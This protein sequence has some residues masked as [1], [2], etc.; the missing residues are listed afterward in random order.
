MAVAGY[1][2][3]IDGGS[4]IDVGNT[5]TYTATGLTPDTAYDFEVRAY[6]E[7]GNRSAWSAVVTASTEPLLFDAM[8][9][10]NVG[11]WDLTQRRAGYT[12]P[13]VK[14]DIG[15]TLTD[16]DFADIEATAANDYKID[17]IYDQ[18]GNGFH[19]TQ[20]T[21]GLRPT[22][23]IS[24]YN[25]KPCFKFT[26]GGAS[27]MRVANFTDWNGLADCQFINAWRQTTL[28]TGFPFIG[29]SGNRQAYWEGNVSNNVYWGEGGGGFNRFT[30]NNTGGMINRFVFDGGGATDALKARFFC[31]RS[32][33]TAGITAAHAATFPNETHLDWNGTP[34]AGGA[35]CSAEYFAFF[36][37]GQD[38]AAGDVTAIEDQLESD[39]FTFADGIITCDG[40]SLIANSANGGSGSANSIPHLVETGL[41]TFT[42]N[43]W[44]SVN[45]GSPAEKLAVEI[46]NGQTSQVS[47]TKDDWR[48]HKVLIWGGTNDLADA[49]GASSAAR[50]DP[51]LTAAADYCQELIDFGWTADDI[52]F[53]TAVT[54]TDAISNADYETDRQ[55]F[56]S[57]LATTLSGI[58]T[59]VD[60]TGIT[61]LADST[62]TDYRVG[63]GVH[64]NDAGNALVANAV[65][66]AIEAT[67]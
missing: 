63:D 47:Q 21:D 22:L 32:E 48:I 1:E 62:D 56:N 5:L 15:G 26:G 65:L 30:K 20:G 12:G 59:V 35:S 44:A 19:F 52:F 50:V 39:Y 55:Y 46:A 43:T 64:L 28:S 29:G 17:T 6:D 25:N 57:N 7:A 13:A 37:I 51:I 41:E 23:S 9:M 42:G 14:V 53:P 24:T 67:L 4:P 49:S 61:E 11:I 54:R 10:T 36:Y 18:S 3:R 58:G 16:I 38:L 34:L 60:L 40:D 31:N 8:S 66:A 27:R 45:Q 2:I 33:V